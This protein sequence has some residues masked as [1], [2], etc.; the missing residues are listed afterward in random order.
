MKKMVLFL[1]V[2]L[3]SSQV[4][5]QVRSCVTF[6]QNRT[7][8][9]FKNVILTWKDPFIKGALWPEYISLVKQA[10]MNSGKNVPTEL[11][12]TREVA[13]RFILDNTEEYENSYFNQSDYLNGVRTADK[14]SYKDVAGNPSSWAV[15][16]KDGIICMYS[17][18]KCCN[19]QFPKVVVRSKPVVEQKTTQP[20]QPQTQPKV[21]PQAQESVND[22][23]RDEQELRYY[24]TQKIRVIYVREEVPVYVRG[25]YSSGYN[26]GGYYGDGYRY[27]SN[28]YRTNY[29]NPA[30]N[31]SFQRQYSQPDRA[32][33]TDRQ[34]NRSY[35]QPA[36]NQ[37]GHHGM[38]GGYGSSGSTAGKSN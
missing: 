31:A 1:L 26:G 24:S 12:S 18:I 27:N 34:P 37:T 11:G 2:A 33:V 29:Y 16:G 30:Y 5:G 3:M 25:G 17:K 20:V 6:D 13:I 36:Y 19:P 35:G 28:Y 38:S 22:Y 15:Y 8:D 32:R 23:S 4:F 21:Q 7:L 14:L 9:G 10:Y